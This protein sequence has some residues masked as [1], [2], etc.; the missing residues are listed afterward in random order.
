VN[1]DF[2]ALRARGAVDWDVVERLWDYGMKERLRIDP[3]E[4]PVLQTGV[5]S[6]VLLTFE[7]TLP[8][9]HTSESASAPKSTRARITELMFEKHQVP[10]FFLAKEAAL[11]CFAAARDK[12][13]V[14][15]AGGGKTTA[16]CVTDGYAL[17]QS[18]QCVCARA[19][20]CMTLR[21]SACQ[22]SPVGGE[23]LTDAMLQWLETQNTTVRPRYAVHRIESAPGSVSARSRTRPHMRRV[24]RR[25]PSRASA[26][27]A[28]SLLPSRYGALG[29]ARHQG[30]ALSCG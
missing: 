13:L 17:R 1:V 19:R 28:D 15:D 2:G 11:S 10:A 27:H 21:P 8:A 23:A 29:G 20:T 16:T 24:H 12:G 14:I 5:H 3:K 9:T 25:I 30:I 6:R 18:E 22:T 4:H 26:T 7:L